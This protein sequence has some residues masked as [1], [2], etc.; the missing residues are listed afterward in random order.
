MAKAPMEA[1]SRSQRSSRAMPVTAACIL[2]LSAEGAAVATVRKNDA[3]GR[4]ARRRAVTAWRRTAHNPCARRDGVPDRCR[5]SAGACAP[6]GN[7]R[8]RGMVTKSTFSRSSTQRRPSSR[9][10][11]RDPQ[12]RAPPISHPP[13]P[14]GSFCKVPKDVEPPPSTASRRL[15]KSLSEHLTLKRI[16]SSNGRETVTP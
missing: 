2:Q 12:S 9:G 13:P 15:R 5:S 8:Q 4:F 3:R 14:L 7:L 6:R 1:P 10:Q 16:E 11:R